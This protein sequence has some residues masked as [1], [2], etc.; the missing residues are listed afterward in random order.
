MLGYAYR[1]LG[2]KEPLNPEPLAM[3]SELEKLEYP[4]QVIR[5]TVS[6]IK[7]I[8]QKIKCPRWKMLDHKL[9]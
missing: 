9:S 8:E 1:V 4:P 2:S 5:S 7:V 3:V 6:L